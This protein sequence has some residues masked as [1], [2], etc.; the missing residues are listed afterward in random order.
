MGIELLR[1]ATPKFEIDWAMHGGIKND[2]G[3]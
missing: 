1:L 2:I 3:P